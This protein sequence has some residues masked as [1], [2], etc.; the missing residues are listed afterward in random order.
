MNDRDIDDG[1]VQI[2]I[3]G[4]LAKRCGLFLAGSIVAFVARDGAVW[5]EGYDERGDLRVINER[6]EG[7]GQ[8][9]KYLRSALRDC[10][11]FRREETPGE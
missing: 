3:S 10:S 9:I 7:L 6:V 11:H 1:N 8:E 2:V 4:S 5:K